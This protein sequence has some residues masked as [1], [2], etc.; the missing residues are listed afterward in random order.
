MDLQSRSSRRCIRSRR[1]RSHP[2][3]CQAIQTSSRSRL[4]LCFSTT[5]P[6]DLR[7]LHARHKPN[8][9]DH[10]PSS[11][12]KGQQKSL[13]V[14]FPH[15]TQPAHVDELW[16]YLWP[17]WRVFMLGTGRPSSSCSAE[18]KSTDSA[19]GLECHRDFRAK[20]EPGLQG[21]CSASVLPVSCMRSTCLSSEHREHSPPS[22]GSARQVRFLWVACMLSRPYLERN[23]SR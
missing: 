5:G 18:P 14:A 6:R 7:D 8:T 2:C 22:R 16:P 3:N 15:T 9:R 21:F 11:P 19:P 12:R 10:L 20:G 13:F 17:S 23:Q 4:C 1:C